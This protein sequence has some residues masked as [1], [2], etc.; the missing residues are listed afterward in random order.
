MATGDVLDNLLRMKHVLRSSSR[1][2][3]AF[4]Y[5]VESLPRPRA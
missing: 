3:A 1:V 4:A 5:R 2:K